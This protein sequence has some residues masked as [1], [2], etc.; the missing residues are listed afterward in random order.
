M[1]S[2]I[3]RTTGAHRG[4]IG[5]L[6]TE[7]FGLVPLNV[8]ETVDDPAT[9]FEVG[10]AVPDPP[11]ALECARADIPPVGELDL[12]EMTGGHGCFLRLLP[13]AEESFANQDCENRCDRPVKI[14][15]KFGF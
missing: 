10:G 7:V 4:G 11:P 13:I 6:A 14:T 15:V 8:L 2:T 1:F 12:V 3:R 5:G 9:N